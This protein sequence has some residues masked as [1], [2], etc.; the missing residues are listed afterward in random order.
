MEPKLIHDN[1]DLK[2]KL[3]Y[4]NESSG[5]TEIITLTLDDWGKVKLHIDQQLQF[6]SRSNYMRQ[7]GNIST[8][9]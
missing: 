7:N 4:F 3:S 8:V 5:K 9:E 2:V 6:A 1:N